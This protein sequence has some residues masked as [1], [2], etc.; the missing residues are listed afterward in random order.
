MKKTALILVMAMVALTACGAEKSSDT[1][2]AT[3]ETAMNAVKDTAAAITK[4]STTV[5]SEAAIAARKAMGPEA[6]IEDFDAQ[7]IAREGDS[8]FVAGTDYMVLTPAQPTSSSAN[9]VEVT[10]VFMLTCPHCFNF[11]PFIKGWLARKPVGVN[12]V[13]IPAQFNKAAELHAAAYY[14][15]E[16]LGVTEQVHLPLFN[17]FHVKRN[18]LSSQAALKEIFVDNGVDGD[19][20]D[21]TFSSF[22]V[23]SNTRQARNLSQR[24][25]IQ[26][27]PTLVINGK[28]VT[29][30]SMAKSIDRL[31]EIVDYLV[32]KELVER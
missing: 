25:K 26:S 20:F 6:G 13:R 19:D 3:T 29:S 24:Y 27:V 21:N 17:A 1:A 11:E 14:T 30:G 32:A 10:E 22:E 2:N 16:A 31:N 5:I 28:F 8:K 23:D 18:P 9:V 4:K 15:A 12:F 7:T